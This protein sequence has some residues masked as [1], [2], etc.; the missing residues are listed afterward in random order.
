MV[1]W[2]LQKHEPV[3]FRDVLD[4]AL[5]NLNDILE[6]KF[7]QNHFCYYDL[8]KRNKVYYFYLSPRWNRF[9]YPLKMM[10]EVCRGE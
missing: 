5:S 4:F 6:K 2:N 9:H 10:P 8:T 7:L 3:K 1:A